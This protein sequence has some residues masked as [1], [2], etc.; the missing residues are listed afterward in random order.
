[1]TTSTLTASVVIPTY[2]R[3]DLLRTCLDHVVAQTVKPERIVVVDAS[4][5]DRSRL[6]VE[7]HGGR[8]VYARN[9]R[10]RGS[11]ATSRNIGVTLVDTD[12]VAF[13]D[14]DAFPRPE[15]LHSLLA[16]Y[17][18]P[19][20]GGV[21]GRI[22][23]GIAGEDRD[24]GE[25]VGRF[26][27]DGTLTGNFST[28]TRRVVAVDHFIGAN[29]SFRKAALERIGGVHDRYPGTCLRE[30]TDLALRVRAAG[31]RLLFTPLACVD[32]VSGPY[33][34]GRRFDVRY[35]YYA[36]RNHLVMVGAITGLRSSQFVGSLKSGLHTAAAHLRR[37]ATSFGQ[38]PAAARWRV[39]PWAGGIAHA[40]AAV[41]G[42]A[43]GSGV[44]LA[45]A[46]QSR[47]DYLARRGSDSWPGR[48]ATW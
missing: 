34:H 30:E 40:A 17:A 1:M 3:P 37:S 22:S 36:Q 15:W 42:L 26:Y 18:D 47:G 6:A 8:V 21:G 4:P 33:A 31:W 46:R 48:S 29:M 2:N 39:R 16:L 44:A 43:V 27:A 38:G 12:I 24:T 35:T 9:P 11:T 45:E 20:V 5:D 14:D 41:S 13:V 28:D 10:G 25:A 19:H 32:H 23:H 7:G